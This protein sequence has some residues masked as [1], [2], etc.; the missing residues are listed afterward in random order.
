MNEIQKAKSAL[1]PMTDSE[2]LLQ[3]RIAMKNAFS[4]L[5]SYPIEKRTEEWSS[6][7]HQLKIMINSI[8]EP[9]DDHDICIFGE[10]IKFEEAKPEQADNTINLAR[11]FSKFP[12]PRYK[13]E[14]QFSGEQFRNEILYPQVI[15]S[16]LAGRQLTV[17]LDGA[18]GYGT[19]FLEESFGGLVRE[20]LVKAEDLKSTI[21]FISNEEPELIPEIWGYVEDASKQIVIP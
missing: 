6:V 5:M 21:Q 7:Q 9:N 12:G 3:A 8:G 14:G 4:L 20:C 17:N 10:T 15:S 19:S 11:D 13:N 1:H 2:L 18:N 16:I